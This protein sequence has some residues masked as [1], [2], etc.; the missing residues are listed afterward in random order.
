L[1]VHS[2]SLLVVKTWPLHEFLPLQALSLPA[3]EPWP[4]Q[5]L[6]CLHCTFAA[7]D[8]PVFSWALAAPA[9]NNEATAEAI[10]APFNVSFNINCSF[11]CGVGEAPP[12][13][14]SFTATELWLGSCPLWRTGSSQ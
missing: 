6:S 13:G 14:G 12:I 11:W 10:T 3:Q 9:M 1:S 5:L 7:A 4:P 8:F 2:F